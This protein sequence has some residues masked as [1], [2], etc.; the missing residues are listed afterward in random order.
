VGA[1]L[2]AEITRRR[3]QRI[4]HNHTQTYLHQL[5]PVVS[6]LNRSR[7][8]DER[9][10]ADVATLHLKLHANMAYMAY[11]SIF[12]LVSC[13]RKYALRRWELEEPGGV[14]H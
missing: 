1:T 9:T 2:E 5:V 11:M 8:R 3:N 12:S 10:G 4:D 6:A 13:G 7:I 14:E